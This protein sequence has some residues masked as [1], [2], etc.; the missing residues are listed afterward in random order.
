MIY[1]TFEDGRSARCLPVVSQPKQ[2]RIQPTDAS[3]CGGV[4]SSCAPSWSDSTA[5]YTTQR[6]GSVTAHLDSIIWRQDCIRPNIYSLLRILSFLEYWRMSFCFRCSTFCWT[7]V[8]MLRLVIHQLVVQHVRNQLEQIR[9]VLFALK[10]QYWTSRHGGR[11]I[12]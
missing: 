5:S 9:A 10:T 8:T 7:E 3:C 4:L 1:R 2:R 6:R 11:R 12:V